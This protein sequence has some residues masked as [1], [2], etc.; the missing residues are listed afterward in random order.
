MVYDYQIID[1]SGEKKDLKVMGE[2]DSR[3][4]AEEGRDRLQMVGCEIYAEVGGQLYRVICEQGKV[5]S[6]YERP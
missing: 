3:R 1:I 6:N 4:G 5:K 2:Y